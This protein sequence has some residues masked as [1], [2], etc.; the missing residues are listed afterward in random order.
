MNDTEPSPSQVAAFE[1]SLK[2]GSARILFYNS[3]V[4]DE[5]TKRLLDLARQ[6][7][8]A[9]VGISETEPP[10]TDYQHWMTGQLDAV[11]KALDAPTH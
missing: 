3:Q 7:H 10:A 5:L 8:V 1:Q 6:S 4:T 11:R 9:V 2:D